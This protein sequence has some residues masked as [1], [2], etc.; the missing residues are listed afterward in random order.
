MAAPEK[1]AVPRIKAER[2]TLR[3]EDERGAGGLRG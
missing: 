1:K 3:Y 2:F